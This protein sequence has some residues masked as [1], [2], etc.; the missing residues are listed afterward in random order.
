[1]V[2]LHT[3]QRGKGDGMPGSHK[4]FYAIYILIWIVTAIHPKYP[5]DWMLENLL[6]ILFFPV[7]LWLDRRFGFSLFALGLMLLFGALH[8]VGAHYTY[9]EVPFFEP[10]RNLFHLERNDYDRVV[11]FLFGLLLFRPLFEILS[12]FVTR[13]GV[14]VFF[15]FCM[16]VAISDLYE[17]LE[18]VATMLF[19]PDLGIAFLG[20]QGDLWDAEKDMLAAVIGAAINAILFLKHYRHLFR[21]HT[22]WQN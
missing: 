10:V 15:T 2:S 5:D 9:A 19:H 7:V 3:R 16:I 6:P 11:H 18:W 14:A 12:H 1:M 20:T 17:I 13:A 21:E 22:S 4:I 8:A